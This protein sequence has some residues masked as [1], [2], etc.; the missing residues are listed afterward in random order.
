MSS[1]SSSVQ[2]FPTPE[3]PPD[4]VLEA[5]LDAMREG[6]LPSVYHLF[7]RA[8]KLEID[9]A[10]RKDARQSEPDPSRRENALRA[11]FELRQSQELLRPNKRSQPSILSVVG[12]PDPPGGRLATKLA[13]VR[14]GSRCYRFTLTR[15][16]AYD[17]GDPRDNDGYGRCWFVWEIQP[18]GKDDGGRDDDSDDDDDD[19]ASRRILHRIEKISTKNIETVFA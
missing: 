2:R 14:V 15:Q 1:S 18:D 17:G 12:D 8:R 4:E 11:F 13:R 9:N 10:A 3:T 6:E 7:S 19:G 5:H 16:S